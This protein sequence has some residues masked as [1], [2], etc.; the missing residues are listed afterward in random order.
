MLLAGGCPAKTLSKLVAYTCCHEQAQERLNLSEII[1]GGTLRQVRFGDTPDCD[2]T[3]C[4][5]CNLRDLL[6]GGAVG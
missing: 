1:I 3:E 5:E 4:L 2:A 6:R